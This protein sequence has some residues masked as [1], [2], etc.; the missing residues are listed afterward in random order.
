MCMHKYIVNQGCR[1]QSGQSGHGLTT[2]TVVFT[3][4]NN[5]PNSIDRYY[6]IKYSDIHKYSNKTVILS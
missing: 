3:S 2:F 6:L 1:N 5:M 4:I